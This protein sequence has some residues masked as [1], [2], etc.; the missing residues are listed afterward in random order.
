MYT[1]DG[2]FLKCDKRY[3]SCQNMIP[4]TFSETASAAT[5]GNSSHCVDASSLDVIIYLHNKSANNISNFP[6][7]L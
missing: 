6:T 7:F 5:G 3:P 4:L 1:T 2:L